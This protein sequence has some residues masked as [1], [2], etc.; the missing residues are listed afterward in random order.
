MRKVFILIFGMTAFLPVLAQKWSVGIV[1]QPC[2]TYYTI[3]G[4]SNSAY[5]SDF[6][7][8]D[9]PV[10]TYQAGLLFS[11]K[12]SDK[13][14]FVTGL[15]YAQHGLQS[16]YSTSN[17]YAL[18]LNPGYSLKVI[19][20]YL[21]IPLYANVYLHKAKISTFF[22]VGLK[23]A[24]YINSFSKAIGVDNQPN[25]F[26]YG[27]HRKVN[28]FAVLGLGAEVKITERWTA[29]IWP[30]LEFAL[31]KEVFAQ[32][33]SIYP[34]SAGVNLCLFYSLGN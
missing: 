13:V 19:D 2:L 28:L 7:A 22:T 10:I 24:F 33:L 27:A 29:L 16:Q 12:M 9:K 31:A 18:G 30:T 26:H 8:A 11:R 17:I 23:P 32:P 15:M 20:R 3:I 4:G 14:N 25:S 21:E 6:R 34:Y 1:G 5:A